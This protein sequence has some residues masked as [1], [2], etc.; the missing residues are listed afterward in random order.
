M[1]K[2]PPTKEKA[3]LDLLD[4]LT[5]ADLMSPNPVSLRKD[6]SVAEATAL[7]VDRGYTGAAVIDDTGRPVGVVSHTDLLIHDREKSNS[8]SIAPKDYYGQELPERVEKG[9]LSRGFQVV[10]VDRATVGSIMTP[11]IFSV[12]PE[13]SARKVMREIVNLQIHRVFVV[14]RAGVLV[15]IVSSIDVLKGLLGEKKD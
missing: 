2:T 3:T 13:S 7:F 5:A 9:G 12:T 1:P 15:G 14:D 8:V 11:V 10:D 4:S 6:A